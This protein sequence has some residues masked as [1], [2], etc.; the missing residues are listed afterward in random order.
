MTLIRKRRPRTKTQKLLICYIFTTINNCKSVR[1]L[2]HKLILIF[3]VII[4]CVVALIAD[5]CDVTNIML[6]YNF[7]FSAEV[8]KCFS[9]SYL[10]CKNTGWYIKHFIYSRFL[11]FIYFYIYYIYYILYIFRNSLLKR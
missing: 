1:R 10:L 7:L 3:I 6:M 8:R 4:F 5:C 2:I 9:F 11:C